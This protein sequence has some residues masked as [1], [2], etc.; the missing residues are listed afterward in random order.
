MTNKFDTKL[1]KVADEFADF[2]LMKPK[3]E[4]VLHFH[5]QE[6]ES[7]FILTVQLKEYA[8]KDIMIERNED[9]SRITISGQ[10]PFQDVLRVQGKVVKKDIEMRGFQKSF[11]VPRGVVF[12]QVLAYFDEDDSEL[13]IQMPKVTKGLVGGQIE[14]L[15]VEE[16]L[17]E[18]TNLLKV[19]TKEELLELERQ[20][21][22]RDNGQDEF[23][24]NSKKDDDEKPKSSRRKF[25]ICTPLIFGSAFVMSLIVLVFHLIESKKEENPQKK[26]KQD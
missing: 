7:M 23:S 20:Q 9:G 15:N 19:Y 3:A 4:P 16:V 11:K 24:A 25:K 13:V 8:R 22:R 18:P 12:D 2:D 14:E 1:M 5:T 26:K 21:V 17:S 6:T 10:K